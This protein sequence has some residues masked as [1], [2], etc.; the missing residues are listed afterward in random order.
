VPVLRGTGCGALLAPVALACDGLELW[1]L[2]WL[3]RWLDVTLSVVGFWTFVWAA[4]I[5]LGAQWP[6]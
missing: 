5:I 3:S 4:A 2:S 1:A 6:V